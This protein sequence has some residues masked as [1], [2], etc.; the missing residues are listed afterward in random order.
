[1]QFRVSNLM[2]GSNFLLFILF[3]VLTIIVAVSL[4]Y[5]SELPKW[6][7]LLI[8]PLASYAGLFAMLKIPELIEGRQKR[9]TLPPGK[10]EEADIGFPITLEG[11]SCPTCGAKD[12]AV[13]LY[14]MVSITEEL[15]KAIAN[16][17]VSLGGC[18]IYD[19][20]P[21]WVCNAC[22]RKF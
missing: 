15:A 3:I 19:G 11:F 2:G 22:N 18:G 13:I 4:L 9:T 21:R 7:A 5:G 16:Q 6:M 10:T 17:R 1:M 12:I 20:A 8:A 14:G